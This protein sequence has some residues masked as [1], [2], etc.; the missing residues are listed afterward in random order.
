MTSSCA[1]AEVS[2]SPAVVPSPVT[3]RVGMHPFVVVVDGLAADG[4]RN[5][6]AQFVNTGL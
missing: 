2:E 6:A 5:D 3:V 1:P 4:L